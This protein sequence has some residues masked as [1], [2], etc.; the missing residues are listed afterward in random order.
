VT[1]NIHVI[2]EA[3]ETIWYG[4]PLTALDTNMLRASDEEQEMCC[5]A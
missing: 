4:F 5:A 2:A 1:K 3:W